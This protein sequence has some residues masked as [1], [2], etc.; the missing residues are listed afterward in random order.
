MSKRQRIVL[1]EGQYAEV[2]LDLWRDEIPCAVK[3]FKERRNYETWSREVQ[4][5]DD[6]KSQYVVKK[7]GQG[8]SMNG[9]LRIT[10]ELCS[11][12]LANIDPK[13]IPQRVQDKYIFQLIEG[14]YAI[15]SM[16]YM[17]RDFKPANILLGVDGTLKISDFGFAIKYVKDRLFTNDVVT[18]Y[19][20]APEL[21]G[22]STSYDDTIDMWALGITLIWMSTY[23][24]V[25]GTSTSLPE[26]LYLELCDLPEKI[27]KS[28]PNTYK[29][30]A[31]LQFLLKVNP[32]ERFS[33]KLAREA[34]KLYK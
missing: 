28:V 17:H 32:R 11:M 26:E 2:I 9:R 19:F 22:G 33:S 21:L 23:L 3:K 7:L 1:G 4:A 13:C 10:M 15:H 30:K 8:H 20:K 27:D 25:P 34:I 6:I 31:L 29:H 12:S 24:P 14:L 18:W 16:G 5:L